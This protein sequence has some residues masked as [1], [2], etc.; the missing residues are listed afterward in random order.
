MILTVG[1]LFT[2]IGGFDLGL[3]R[4]GMKVLW[5][6]END[7][8]CNKVLERH[9]PGVRRFGDIQTLDIAR[10]EPVDVICGGDPC[11]KHSRARSNGASS[12]PD[13][14]GYFLA[15]VGRLCPWWVVRENVP[16]PTVN[17]FA[18]GLEAL[19][20]GTV[21]IRI[22]AAQVTGQSRQ[23]D[24]TVGCYSASAPDVN[25]TVF[26]NCENGPGA[27]TTRLGA[28]QIAP[29]LT[30]HRTRYDSRDCYIWSQSYGLRILESEERERLAGLPENWTAG[31]S[32]AKRAKFCGNAVVPQIAEWIGWQIIKGINSANP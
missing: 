16:A 21:T 11:P 1:S 14:S 3:E 18:L 8:Y 5:Q 12:H 32:P 15:L 29:A 10:L 4:A 17:H 22:D 6:V 31:F 13:L 9:W 25:G 23:R 20:Y 26:P 24:F 30:C 28:R 7:A 2:G 27:Y 19:G